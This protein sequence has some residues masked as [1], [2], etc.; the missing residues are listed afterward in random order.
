MKHEEFNPVLFEEAYDALLERFSEY[1]EGC[2]KR[3]SAASDAQK[4]AN[5]AGEAPKKQAPRKKPEVA[6]KPDAKPKRKKSCRQPLQSYSESLN[7]QEQE[8]IFSYDPYGDDR[9]G[10]VGK[11]IK[12]LVIDID[13]EK[14]KEKKKDMEEKLQILREARSQMSKRGES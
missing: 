1:E 9:E 14:D 11:S 10:K 7:F 2:P 3:R 4:K 13:L 6:K 5:Q 12:K 8:D